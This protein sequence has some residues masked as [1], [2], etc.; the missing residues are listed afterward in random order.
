MKRILLCVIT[1]CI[2]LSLPFVFLACGKADGTELFGRWE[3][4]MVDEELGRFSIVYHFTEQGE[5]FIE[6]KQGDAI[7]F[8]I[9]FGTWTAKGNTVTIESDGTEETFT[10]S[11]QGTELLLSQGEKA[12]LVF[13][14]I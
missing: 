4:E 7:P 13:R 5:I 6:Q 1:L 14:R 3:T 9:P 2:L 11:V 8:S 12:N 10:F